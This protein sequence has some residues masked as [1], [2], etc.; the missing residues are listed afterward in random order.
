MAS[1][2]DERDDQRKL[3]RSSSGTYASG[4][5]RSTTL[6]ERRLLR[7]E[8][9]G[10]CAG[11]RNFLTFW[12]WPPPGLRRP[13]GER[14][15]WRMRASPLAG[16][17][18]SFIGGARR[19][20]SSVRRRRVEELRAGARGRAGAFRSRSGRAGLFAARWRSPGASGSTTSSSLDGVGTRA[21]RADSA[22]NAWRGRADALTWSSR[23]PSSPSHAADLRTTRPS[24][25]VGRRRRVRVQRP[26][27]RQLSRARLRCVED[28][29]LRS[30]RGD[31][32]SA[33]RASGA[34]PALPSKVFV[35][36]LGATWRRHLD[37]VATDRSSEELPPRLSRRRPTRHTQF[38]AGATSASPLSL[39]LTCS[40]Q[41]GARPSCASD[42]DALHQADAQPRAKVAGSGGLR[43]TNAAS[44]SPAGR[45][46]PRWRECAAW[47]VVDAAILRLSLADAASAALVAEQLTGRRLANAR[48]ARRLRALASCAARCAASPPR[49][50]RR[51]AATPSASASCSTPLVAR[52][53][54]RRSTR[55]AAAVACA[56]AAGAPA[57]RRCSPR[58]CTRRTRRRPRAAR[59]PARSSAR[60]AR[61]RRRGRRG[62]RRVGRRPRTSRRSS[63]RRSRRLAAVRAASA[64]ALAA[65]TADEWEG[66]LQPAVLRALK[67]TPDACVAS[68]AAV[69]AAVPAAVR[70]DGAAADLADALQP[71]LL[72]AAAPRAAAAAA[73]I[74]ALR[75]RVAQEEGAARVVKA[76]AAAKKADLSARRSA[77]RWRRRSRRARSAPPALGGGRRRARRARAAGGE[78]DAGGRARAA[79]LSAAGLDRVPH[80]KDGAAA[81]AALQEGRRREERGGAARAPRRHPDA[82]AHAAVGRRRRARRRLPA[83]ARPPPRPARRRRR[84]ARRRRRRRALPQGGRGGGG[85]GVR[86]AGG[87]AQAGRAVHRRRQ[88]RAQ[89]GPSGAARADA[90]GALCCVLEGA[91]ACAAVE[92]AAAAEKV[93]RSASSRRTR[94]SGPPS[95]ACGVRDRARGGAADRLLTVLHLHAPAQHALCGDGDAP[96]LKAL[97]QLGFDPYGLPRAG[98]A[99]SQPRARRAGSTRAERAPSPE[100]LL[101]ARRGRRPREAGRAAGRPECVP[102]PPRRRRRGRR[103]RLD[104]AACARAA[105][106]ARGAGGDAGGGGGRALLARPLPLRTPPR[107]SPARRR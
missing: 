5:R 2:V 81:V 107:T 58:T 93:G 65:L 63:R 17:L 1:L 30:R 31:A 35:A 11:P 39:S 98:V 85:G 48:A 96:L 23:P 13:V 42:E 88:G 101:A 80:A 45:R 55:C 61:R 3:H 87:A 7:R 8:S 33:A 32:A 15:S 105:R 92:K 68:L 24:L 90:L 75:R 60:P 28:E 91:V 6:R 89:V 66:T 53:G 99:S 10:I 78:G 51:S 106:S 9:Q 38:P 97:V 73:A 12:C 4:E 41:G 82:R 20:G 79:L 22:T 21:V 37:P 54:G 86:A 44:A 16:S 18:A 77:P 19:C 57:R 25:Q 14:S 34:G 74:A 59:S 26:R 47:H 72:G 64:P 102:P 70:L 49:R 69:L 56:L 95:T 43:P 46:R 84:R 104:A 76:L 83:L 103:R 27:R 40:C 52:A 62:A 50:R 100:A 94:S 29:G 67:R 36:G 71:L